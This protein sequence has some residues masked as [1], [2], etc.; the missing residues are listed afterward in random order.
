MDDSVLV[1]HV[2]DDPTARQRVV[3]ALRDVERPVETVAV[4]D[5]TAGRDRVAAGDADVVVSAYDLPDGDGLELLDRIRDVS[6]DVPFVLFTGSGDETVASRAISAG[7]T[8]YVRKGA[9]DAEAGIRRAIIEAA[10]KRRSGSE[11]PSR[12]ESGDANE[13]GSKRAVEVLEATDDGAVPSIVHSLGDPVYVLDDTGH[14]R[15]VNPALEETYGYDADD[16]V[17]EH[18]TEFVSDSCYERGTEVLLSALRSGERSPETFEFVG[19]D[20]DGEEIVAEVTAAPLV[21]DGELVGSVGT[22]HDVTERKCRQE[23]LET[24]RT[25]V[26][27]VSDPMFQLDAFG[28]LEMVN[29]AMIEF[30]GYERE[31][32]TDMHFTDFLDPEA[33]AVSERLV[34]ELLSEDGDGTAIHEFSSTTKDGDEKIVEDSLTVLTDDEGNFA[35][36]VGVLREITERK[37]R[38]EELLQYETLLETVPIGMFT[39]DENGVLTWSNEESYELLDVAGH[40]FEE[41]YVGEPYLKL[42]DDGFFDLDHVEVYRDS[43]REMLSSESNTRKAINDVQVHRE[44]GTTRIVDAH[45]G[46]LPMNDGE[47]SGTVTAFRDITKQKEYQWELERQNERLER[48]ASVVSHDL[49]NPLNVAQGHLDAA[50][51]AD[52]PLAAI[53]EVEVSLD[54][55][56]EL[57]DD[58]LALARN[59]KSVAEPSP[60]DLRTIVDDAWETAETEA[61]TLHNET[62]ATVMA[63][64]SRVRQ[65]LENCFRNS[66]EHG[67]SANTDAS[68]TITVGDLPDGFYLEDDGRGIPDDRKEQVFDLG[69]TTESTG[70]GFGLGIVSEIVDAHGWEVKAVDGDEGGARLEV[71][72]VDRAEVE[73]T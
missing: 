7:V 1:L 39:V 49:R 54:R 29:D 60:T 65:L 36:S 16:L 41:E 31:E 18:L 20:A 63:D 71:T 45:S 4:D 44:D 27:T 50:K 68:V 34:R 13:A 19:E 22:L 55:M 52:D 46:L 11:S 48:F 17:G 12:E 66:V 42:V 72:G 43:V 24:Y 64:A 62:T 8:E 28:N 6:D 35:G 69:Y 10:E 47:F 30:A 53:E 2:D 58:I 26:E 61:A 21:D 56:R 38:E 59:G 37:E 23:E 14:I 33:V 5:A 40:R 3:E 9:T 15:T 51:T 32:L 25:L 73:L 57:I 67:S 70:T